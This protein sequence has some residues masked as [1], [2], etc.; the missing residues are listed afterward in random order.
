MRRIF[1]VVAATAAAAVLAGCAG[2]GD[3]DTPTPSTSS[4]ETTASESAAPVQGDRLLA[5]TSDP[6]GSEIRWVDARTLEPVDD[7]GVKVPFY[8]SSAEL[9]PD[10]GVLAIGEGEGGRVQF[11]DVDRMHAL[12][13]VDVDE[14]SYVDRILWAEPEVVL[15][16]L[17]GTPGM[18][19]AIDP[20]TRKVVS[21]HDLG[22]ATLYSQ[23]A[24]K[25]LV[26]LVAPTSRIGPARLVVFDGREVR[27]VTLTEVP[28]GW[29]QLEDADSSDYVARQSVPALAVNEEGTRALVIPAGGRVA[30]IDLDTMQISYHDLS[31]PVSLWG[32]LRD[33]LEPAA[34]AKAI[35]GPDRNA[36]WLPSGLV[37]VSGAQYTM[38][39]D[40]MDMTPAGLVL[41]DPSDWSVHRLSDEP[42]WVTLRGGALLASVWNDGSNEQKLIVFDEDGEHRFTL[43]REATDL[44]QTWGSWL[45]ATSSNGTRFEIV[46]LES[47]KTVGR[48]QPRHETWLLPFDL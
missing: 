19:A 3:A 22:G 29:A 1:L 27:E 39:G 31:E 37:A 42:S 5:A 13:T 26:S 28:A 33:W 17:G 43:T 18:V 21:V 14:A 25:E 11:V 36:V 41:I 40:Q 35:D 32:R 24:G 30:D 46:D 45:Y 6:I 15:A 10:H 47:G 38:D 16:S 8:T 23:P 12:G 9:S 48:A 34:Q 2:S 7:R 4:G 20:T 44:S